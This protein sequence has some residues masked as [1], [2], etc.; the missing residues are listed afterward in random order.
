MA[1]EEKEEKVFSLPQLQ[2]LMRRDP[3]AY[4]PEFQQQWSHFG[5]MVDIFKLKPQKPHKTFGEHVMF[6][7]HVSP[8]F[9]GRGLELATVITSVLNEHSEI[10]HAEMRLVLVQALIMLRNRSQY[11]S[12][13]TLPLY[14]KL[15]AL[16]DKNLRKVLLK[17]IVR[18]I[19]QMNKSSR[20]HKTVGELR[21]FFFSQ[22]KNADAEV[23]RR[24]CAVFISLYRQDIWTNGQVVNL[25]STG[26]LHPDTKIAAAL[27]HLFLGNRMK[28][29]DGILEDSDD[30][31]DE[32]ADE[33]ET[34]QGLFGSKKTARKEKRVARAKKA[35]KKAKAK[36]GQKA[37]DKGIISF[38][39]IDLLNDPQTLAERLL[40]RISKTGEPYRFRLLLLHVIGRL[41]SR[42]EL[43]L[44][45]LYPFLLKYLQP[46]QMEVTKVMACLVEATH[47]Q[48]PP[49]ELRPVVLHIMKIF[50]TEAQAPEVIEVGLN[51]IRSVCSR[52]I[53][54]LTEEELA[55]LASFRK[56]R[57]KGVL[58]AAR[59]LINTYRELHPRLLERSL[60]GREAQMAISQGTLQDPQFGSSQAN[61]NIEGIELLVKNSEN[62]KDG[63][64]QMAQEGVLST[65]DFRKLRKLR[66]QKSVEM[67]LGKKRKAN[68]IDSSSGSEDEADD[69][70]GD[71]GLVG[72]LPGAVSADDLKS[73]QKK[74][75]KEARVA[76]A[77]AG[78]IDPKEAYKEKRKKLRKGGQ[79]NQ[80]QKRH[81]PLMMAKQSRDAQRKHNMSAQEKVRSLKKHIGTLKKKVGGKQ[82]RRR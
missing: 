19:V 5:S 71:E 77:K 6:L 26:L 74:K 63:A 49:D 13:Q 16:Q 76:T 72:R 54:V 12:M 69:A 33:M 40:Q 75:G 4:A 18:D 51:T 62:E 38:V 34:L 57:N 68:D 21:D 65:E 32:K 9:P 79:T 25:I 14:F 80:E 30:E 20:D 61:A 41:V 17:H 66:M 48:V 52:A 58:M 35:I 1:E 7:A 82:K 22:M 2:N 11:P 10:M 28:G 50:V 15:F 39:A 53:N 27:S 45:N 73:S 44:L 24:A 43:H 23:S 47:P 8:S 29:L 36:K 64:Q 56:T 67:Q 31:E 81:K 78:R 37:S 46:K 55:D 3:E 59:S 42:H 60:R 70:E